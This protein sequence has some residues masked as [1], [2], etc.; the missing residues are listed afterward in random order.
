MR[1]AVFLFLSLV[2]SALSALDFLHH[3]N[4]FIFTG[5]I[6][7]TYRRKVNVKA[8]LLSSVDLFA[9]VYLDTLNEPIYDSGRQFCDLGTLTNGFEESAEI[10]FILFYHL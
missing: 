3:F 4:K 5:D 6:N 10:H 7:K 2:L 1:Y 9:L 8:H